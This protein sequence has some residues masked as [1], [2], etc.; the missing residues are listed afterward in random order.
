MENH[1]KPVK[2]IIFIMFYCLFL[3]VAAQAQGKQKVTVSPKCNTVISVMNTIEKQT[4]LTFFYNTNE[5]DISR[6]VR[7][8]DKRQDLT[9]ALNSLFAGTG[10]K[11]EFRDRS[12]VLRVKA[13]PA[14]SGDKQPTTRKMK[15]AGK[16]LDAADEPVVGAIVRE[17]SNPSNGAITDIN[18]NYSIEVPSGATLELSYIGYKSQTIRANK[19]NIT[20]TMEEDS[21]VMDEVVV[22]GYGTQRRSDVTGA[23]SSFSQKDITEV[24]TSNVLK[25]MQGKVSGLDITQSSG[26]P[27]SSLTLTLRGNRSLSADNS[28]LIL[29][30]GVEYGSVVDINPTD[31]ESIE[32]LKDIS[33]TA[34]YGTKGANGVVI[35]TTKRGKKSSRTNVSFNAYVAFK[36]ASAYPRMMNGQE[37]AQ[38]RREAYRTDNNDEYLADELIFGEEELYDINNDIWVDWHDL[39]LHHAVTQNYEANMSGGN[40]KT[41]YLFS[42][43]LQRDNGLLKNDNLTRYNGRLALDH[44]ISKMFKVGVSILYT[45]KKQNKRDNPLNMANKINPIGEAYEED[46]SIR[47]YPV[48]GNTSS[49]SPIADEIDGNFKDEVKA[50]RMFSTAYLQVTILPKLIFKSSI[51]LD[52]QDTRE[53]TYKGKY[54]LANIGQ[55]STSSLKYVSNDKYTWDNTLSYETTLG[56]KHRLAAMIGSSTIKNAIETGYMAGANQASETTSF[57]DI[58]SNTDSKEMNSSLV[59]TQMLS[60]FG[61]VHY[62]YNERYLLQA[63]LRADGSSVLAKGHKWGYFP[64][65]SA[66]WRMSEEKFM[67]GISFISNLKLRL[68]WGVA[69]NSAIDAYSTLGSLSKSIYA[70]GSSGVY[71]YWPSE[72]ANHDLTWEKTATWNLGLDFGFFNNRIN[73]SIE[74][75]IAKTSDLLLPASLPRST[76]YESIYQNVGKTEN[77][78]LELTLNTQW[79]KNKDL[80]W[81]TNWTFMTNHEEIK[82]LN[83]GVDRNEASLWFVG[84]PVQVYYDYKKIGIWQTSEKEAA[85]AFGGFI[86]GQIKVADAN[87]N[88]TYD[89]DDRVVFSRVPKY[90]FG[91]NNTISYKGF[92]LT[93][94]VYGR[95]GQYI[96]YEYNTLFT[97]TNETAA[98]VDYWTPENPTNEFPRASVSGKFDINRTSMQYVK[99]SYIKIKDIT[100]GYTVPEK[101]PPSST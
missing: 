17:K 30:D 37:Y 56:S 99:G 21:Q 16:V 76:G 79:I 3:P 38:L 23:I 46:G 41:A 74:A 36:G 8:S 49:V 97:F 82:K 40:D 62:N 65:V 1:R 90:S 89:T 47:A 63:T 6:S 68:S 45:Y 9:A 93:A 101:S 64:S 14:T 42:F 5:I 70:F 84:E 22:V 96:K 55:K 80:Q 77:K 32:I 10:V 61:R 81:E 34:I 88:G 58:G 54:T 20:V 100:L 28:P 53:G 73:G 13:R 72:I 39:C 27:G 18:G 94:F 24:P 26:Q 57:H 85:A 50:K 35:I 25:T 43:G 86:P 31:I 12:I 83:S 98:A 78:G 60:F 19:Q 71:G 2:A 44:D 92:D 48:P 87:N 51:G 33:S 66:A 59:E 15:V 4:G 29:V 11:Y 69:G 95:I 91:I 67:K 7:L 52:L 75:Y